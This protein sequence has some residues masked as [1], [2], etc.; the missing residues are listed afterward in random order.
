MIELKN[1]LD[2]V[3]IFSQLNISNIYKYKRKL[4]SDDILSFDIEVTSLFDIEE[5]LKSFDY[6]KSKDYYIGRDKKALP[7]IWQFGYNDKVYYSRNFYDFTTLL[8]TI[9]N[10]NIH[11]FIYV[12]N[13]A[14]EF[15]FLVNIIKKMG[16]TIENLLARGLRK[17]IQFSIKELNITF[18]CSFALTNLSLQKSGEQF[19]T[20]H[21]KLVG[22]L[23]YNVARSPLT[24]LTKEEL[25]YC[26]NDILVMYEFLQIY[27]REYGHIKNIPI[28]QTGEVRKDLNTRIHYPYRQH[29][30]RTVPNPIIMQ[31][32]MW[33]FMGGQVHANMIHS[34]KVINNMGSFD[35]SS[36]YPFTM[37]T[38]QFPDSQFF[39]IDED[40]I[41]DFKKCCCILYHV[42]FYNFKSKL[43]NNYIP[44]S[45]CVGK[46][47]C[48]YDNGRII[49]GDE[50]E[51]CITDID[52]EIIRESY[53]IE[54]IEYIDIYASYKK[55]LP[56]EII[57]FLL[58]YY[59]NKTKLKGIESQEYL[60][61]KS[62]QKINSSFGCA[63]TNPLK[64]N[65]ILDL[66]NKENIWKNGEFSEEFIEK[67]LEQ[68]KESFSTIF[69]FATGCWIT[70]ISRKGL[71]N[72]IKQT[73]KDTVYYDTDSDKIKDYKKYLPVIEN[74]NKENYR[75]IEEVCDFYGIDIELFSPTD[76]K[77]KK[78]T[79]GML[80]F[81]GEY[82][83]FKTLGAK[84]YCYRDEKNVLHMTLSGV[85]KSA[86]CQLNNDINN[87]KKGFEFDYSINKLNMIYLENQEPFT[88]LDCNNVEYTCDNI[89]FAIIAQPTTYTL[90]ITQEY[91][92]LLQYLEEKDTIY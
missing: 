20:P 33:S 87:F 23:D 64:Q 4:Y 58:E 1:K 38:S 82:K 77:G 75:K 26:E 40:E 3:S 85:R 43:Y 54:K 6:S 34:G 70:A 86:V 81:E 15:H 67:K 44:S 14:Y 16:W 60:Y 7:Y 68:M 55:Y 80:E 17:V 48:R 50:I 90:G 41:E 8:L 9:S 19:N 62:K 36:R 25:G 61:M 89:Q 79:L 27:K 69:S 52:F 12:H 24:P 66:E 39:R 91:E 71:W 63:V 37:A 56:K 13:L 74:I 28:T 57:L 83:E 84:K 30:W 72:I 10:E 65:Y 45:K 5:E 92:N 49:K 31:M 2:I 22:D 46:K 18:R 32:L 76:T 29:I 53:N 78:H 59:N 21:S 42:K 51:M 47:G 35:Y 73:D 11:Q 88:F